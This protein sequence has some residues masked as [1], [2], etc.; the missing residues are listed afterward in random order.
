MWL[1]FLYTISFTVYFVRYFDSTTISPLPIFSFFL[2]LSLS[3]HLYLVDPAHVHDHC[4]LDNI[5]TILMN[6]CPCGWWYFLIITSSYLSGKTKNKRKINKVGWLH[7][8]VF[9]S[10]PFSD[11]EGTF[12]LMTVAAQMANPLKL[13]IIISFISNM[14][15]ETVFFTFFL[16]NCLLLTEFRSPSLFSFESHFLF[17]CCGSFPTNAIKNK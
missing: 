14:N 4:I 7:C 8:L 13:D 10:V 15:I 16:I 12:V 6:I 9:E 1:S 11:L 17:E 2:C 5:I 3:I